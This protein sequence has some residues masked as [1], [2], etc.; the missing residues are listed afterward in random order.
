MPDMRAYVPG[1][2]IPDP[3]ADSHIQ[4]TAQ[5]LAARG[6][7]AATAIRS[8]LAVLAYGVFAGIVSDI[9]D[10]STGAIG[11]VLEIIT[12][13]L[14]ALALAALVMVAAD[15]VRL[16][17]RDPADRAEAASQL[18]A[19]SQPRRRH[20]PAPA[21]RPASWQARVFL[22]SLLALWLLVMAGYLPQ[23]VNAI[24]YLAGSG[25]TVQFTGQSYGLS[26]GARSGCFTVTNGVLLTRP[27][28]RA[29]WTGRAPLHRAFAVRDPA[30][31][32]WSSPVQLMD[33]TWAGLLLGFGVFLDLISAGV[34]TALIWT[35]RRRLRRRRA[36]GISGT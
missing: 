19:A 5:L 33:G 6:E 27:P 22:G 21:P 36:A 24:A 7:W 2:D 14:A 26:C 20:G 32:G 15:T 28:A 1:S 29:T 34:L 10:H 9:T 17:G 4:E 16:R 30:W 23:Q 8:L 3:G 11:T 31:A 25:T 35:L 13:A 12:I 18:K